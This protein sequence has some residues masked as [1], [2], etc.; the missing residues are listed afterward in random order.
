MDNISGVILTFTALNETDEI[1][2]LI[3]F[4]FSL[5]SF[6]LTVFLNSMLIL[7]IVV[8][9][10]LHEPMY[11]FLGNLCLNGLC[12][13]AGFYPKLLFD[14]IM[15]TTSVSL[16]ACI[17]QSY[18]VFMYGIGEITNLSVMALDRYLAICRPLYYHS[19]M[20]RATVMK[21]LTFIWM[22]PFCTVL[23]IILM[24]ARNPICGRH[25]DKLYCG[26]FFLER[27]ACQTHISEAIIKGF[28][29]FLLDI[30]MAF[31]FFSYIK[32]II[33]CK[34]SKVN[35]SKFM[36]TCLPHLIA[37]SN[38]M[39][40]SLLDA[41]HTQFNVDLPQTLQHFNSAL[42][43]VIPPFVNPIIYG[44]KLSPIRTHALYFAKKLQ[45]NA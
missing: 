30:L 43:L 16:Q 19:L 29:F 3:I 25:M 42:I 41:S 2:K 5:T 1:S 45:F 14:L 27:L 20:C 26:S 23:V 11:I 17:V 22:F 33:A 24:A 21:L 44:I 36:S 40:L 31:V 15:Q 35:Q 32:L 6:F 28:F 34:Q 37:F 9:K 38:F 4:A 10:T 18:V 12:G 8:E 7:I 39:A 13:T